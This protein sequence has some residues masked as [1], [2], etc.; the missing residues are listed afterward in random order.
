AGV[1]GPERHDPDTGAVAHGDELG[2]ERGAGGGDDEGVRHRQMRPELL[3]RGDRRDHPHPGA[4]E[5]GGELCGAG[6]IEGD[7]HRGHEPDP[8][9]TTDRAAPSVIAARTAATS[10]RSMMISSAVLRS[11]S[12]PSSSGTD[13]TTTS[14]TRMRGAS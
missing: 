12:T 4:L 2:G 5:A 13:A 10:A 9:G 6:L 11:A 1:P 8:I 14:A 3:L 7:H